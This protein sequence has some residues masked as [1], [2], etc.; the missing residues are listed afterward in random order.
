[1]AV[2][3]VEKKSAEIDGRPITWNVLSITGYLAGDFQTLEVKLDRT[4]AM[5]AGML[6][7]SDENAPTVHSGGKGEKIDVKRKSSTADDDM[8]DFL[9]LNKK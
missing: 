6:L 5:L 1:M 4:Q 2:V 7:A 9:G 8:D 3:K